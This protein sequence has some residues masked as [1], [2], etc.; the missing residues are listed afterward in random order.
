MAE[1]PLAPPTPDSPVLRGFL[2]HFAVAPVGDPVRTLV[3]VATAFS[4][5]PYEN[6]TKIIKNA[7]AGIAA[8]ARRTPAEVWT[9]HVRW[10]AGGTCF[11]LTAALLHLV[12]ALGWKAEPILADRRYGENTHSAIVVWIEGHPHLLDPGYLIVDP[13]PLPKTGERVVPG[14]IND[15]VLTVRDEGRKIDLATRQRGT[16]K[17]RLTFK[18]DPVAPPDFLRAWDV[19]FGFEAMRYPVLTKIA[20]DRQSYL[21]RNRLIRKDRDASQGLE[22]AADELVRRIAEEFGV[23]P[24]IVGKALAI[25]QRKGVRHGGAA[26]G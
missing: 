26:G 22:F 17:H 24:E 8:D 21:Q 23:A 15:R 9:D 16:T 18:T 4:R 11:A 12:R 1:D 2:R 6:L 14:R 13:L 7:E 20:D 25:L 5:L 10:G 19:S 3:Q